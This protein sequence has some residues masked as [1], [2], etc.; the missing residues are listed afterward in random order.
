MLCG[1]REKSV[2]RYEPNDFDQ[3]QRWL[4]ARDCAR[5]ESHLMPPFGQI[6]DGVAA[7]FVKETDANFAV[8]DYFCTNPNAGI[9]ER[10]KATK[11]MLVGA[12][13]HAQSQ[14]FPYVI[15]NTRNRG[16]INY[17][18]RIGFHMDETPYYC[19]RRSVTHEEAVDPMVREFV[20]SDTET[21][22]DWLCD[23]LSFF[24]GNGP[25]PKLGVIVDGLG[26]AFLIRTNCGEAIL[27]AF[28]T[29]REAP[30]EK[31]IRA[32]NELTKAVIDLAF[33]NGF[34]SIVGSTKSLRG[35]S[36]LCKHGFAYE[37]RPYFFLRKKLKGVSDER[38][39]RSGRSNIDGIGAGSGVDLV[40][41]DL[42]RE[43]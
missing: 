39:I 9:I 31:R 32:A 30:V 27:D 41:Y 13:E 8:L 11:E 14:G 2:R 21:V 40:T 42:G 33:R 22:K 37:N 15:G 16:M 23:R 35:M 7:G 26:C 3:I 5:F 12:F 43:A 19:F 1:L 29:N 38:R 20:E 6:M 36:L 17:G 34:R 28:A 4:D 24:H 18:K 25:L 10:M